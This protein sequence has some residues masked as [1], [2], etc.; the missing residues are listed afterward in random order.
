MSLSHDLAAAPLSQLAI[1]VL[2]VE[3]ATAFYRDKLGLPFLFAFPGLAFF[4]SGQVRLMLSKAEAGEHDHPASVMYFK[5]GSVET[6]HATLVERGVTF[7]DQPHV[8]H[9]APTYHLWMAFLKDPEG[10]TLAV[11]EERPV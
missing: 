3:R 10:N 8:V 1:R 5:V 4:Q 2:D 9:R 6:T 11:M 7:V